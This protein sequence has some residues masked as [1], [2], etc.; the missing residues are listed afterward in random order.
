MLHTLLWKRC[1]ELISNAGG[2]GTAQPIPRPSE[3]RAQRNYAVDRKSFEDESQHRQNVQQN[4]ISE[5]Q[6]RV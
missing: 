1:L 5:A 2:P 6:R 3:T 4:T